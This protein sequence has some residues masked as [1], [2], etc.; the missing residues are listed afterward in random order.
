MPKI[1][2]ISVSASKSYL[3]RALAISV[4]CQGKTV[5]ENTS[6]SNDSLASKKI[7]EQLGATTK[8]SK[9]TLEIFSNGLAFNNISF[10]AFES[11]LTVRMF[12]PILALH[13]EETTIYG[14][15][16]LNNRPV[17]MIAEA[18]N[19][20]NV[21][22]NC[23][24]KHLPLNIQGPI[25]SGE[26]TI[27]GSISSQLL[28][29][30]LI[31]LPLVNGD[32]IIKVTDLKSRPYIDMTI[33]II[34]KFGVHI[35][36]RDYKTFFI[37]GNQK[38]KATNYNIE[39]D[40]S[41]AAFFLVYGAIKNSIE[42]D[43][44]NLN[45]LQADKQIILALK[46]AGAKIS[47]NSNSIIVEKNQLKAFDFD[48]TNCP[49][50]FPPLVC[51][52]SQCRGETTIKGVSR[53]E[54]KESNRGQVLLTEFKKMGIKI[55]IKNDTMRIVGG[56]IKACTIDSHHDHRIAMSG[57]IMNLLCEG[58][59]EIKNKDAINK[60][61]PNFFNELYSLSDIKK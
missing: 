6:W 42:I 4:L 1:P 11:G 10:N 30:L 9:K 13:N 18:L 26:I 46:R 56:N 8:E 19:Q 32:S 38:Y 60:S 35:E 33:D 41:S 61:Y 3:Q 50:L 20:L 22:V 58:N 59:I 14:E 34:R 12:A 48:A 29:G 49:D 51:L 5:L 53:L 24:E 27:D 25:K 40:W 7:I 45:S 23:N 2:K 15:G 36:N 31:T 16:S 44:L 55:S 47:L 17:E 57:G 54:Y 52:A 37:K 39:G 21:K 43:N 28:T